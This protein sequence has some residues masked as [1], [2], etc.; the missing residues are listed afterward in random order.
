MKIN[1][2]ALFGLLCSVLAL[3]A[4]PAQAGGSQ[5]S[6]KWAFYKGTSG[7]QATVSGQ[8]ANVVTATVSNGSHLTFAG[9]KTLDNGL[10]ETRIGVTQSYEAT[11]TNDN[12]LTFRVAV[13][14]GYTFKVTRAAF[15]ATRVGTDQVSVDV[16]V[17]GKKL[18]TGLVPAR[19][20]ANPEFTTYSY[21]IADDKA[22][23][24]HNLSLNIYNLLN[25]KQV[26]IANVIVEGIVEETS[27]DDNQQQGGNQQ[28]DN[29]QS[30]QP[31]ISYPSQG[32]IYWTFKQ[33]TANQQP[34]LTSDFN[35]KVSGST[36]VGS[37]I[38]L[39]GQKVL[40]SGYTE[41]RVGVKVD[42][43]QGANDNNKLSFQVTPA[44]GYKVN[45]T[46]IQFTATQIGT[47]VGKLDVSWAGKKLATAVQPART[48]AD[49]EFTTYT[50]NVSTSN[51]EKAHKLTL[52]FYNMPTAKQFGIADIIFYG[53]IE[54]AE[55]Q[56]PSDQGGNSG[57]TYTPSKNL[58]EQVNGKTLAFPGAEGFGAFSVGG[59][60]GSV[61]HVTNLN[62][63]GA[64]SFADAIS[65][66][67]RII[68]FDVGGIINITGK[69]LICSDN[70]TIE[71]QTAPG[72]GI[73][74]YGG[75]LVAKGKNQIIRFIRVRGGIN[76]NKT[77]AAFTGDEATDLI[78]DHCS[79][80][81]G[82]WDNVH[83][84]DATRVTWQDCIISEGIDP[85]R[86]G[87]IVDG[88][89]Q[90]TISHCLW[91]DN[92]SRNPKMK[93]NAQMINSI[94]YN[95]QN[96]T[97]G[98]HS[99]A[100]WYQDV[101][102][103]YYISGPNTSSASYFSQWSATDHLYSAGN[104][105]DHNKNGRLDGQACTSY[106]GATRM[107]RP[108]NVSEV[109]VTVQSASDAYYTV[110]KGVGASL[111]R[112]S[113]DK[114]VISQV[115]SLGRSGQIINS[116]SNVGG[117]GTVRNGQKAKDSD[118]DGI[119]D[120]FEQKYGLN[121]H[122]NDAMAYTLSKRYTNIEVYCNSLVE[123]I[124]RESN[125]SSYSRSKGNDWEEEEETTTGVEEAVAD[126]A[127]EVES[128]RYYNLSGA[129]VSKS[130]A[131]GIVIVKTLYS[132]GKQTTRKMVI[133]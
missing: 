123:N 33:G 101:I 127:P 64:G 74:L 34:T 5:V 39:A 67:N 116:E 131:K 68:I 29:N 113:H 97:V 124:M 40:S 90:W 57:K 55:T 77:K 11:A 119:P 98:G 37:N 99:S 30:Q 27:V 28:Q 133:R 21:T 82:R 115:E 50:Y 6:V 9:T 16:S 110:V 1:Q 26:G 106:S 79:V 75:R 72:E 12:K 89:S 24:G 103:N 62:A 35:G 130:E 121:Q 104:F 92:H 23:S 58:T 95:Y 43:E 19:N 118:G 48:K 78:L 69:T 73:T 8:Y 66:P 38:T 94:V 3:F 114:R 88:T 51:P 61:Y 126:N 15:T 93:A 41:T 108:S 45:I 2:S 44:N 87:A 120:W 36:I 117:I 46:K 102:N 100:N 122:G 54:K 129:E 22:T 7:Q 13:A 17:S 14:D 125:P 4:T 20:K 49:P 86:F 42:N 53:T 91:A 85:Q 111:V 10:T 47:D 76:L 132:N 32:G 96:G 128:V 109:P 83:M 81:W 80:S 112:D 31:N 18:A 52:N 107:N 84:K 71:G 56:Q 63:S 65:R 70:I 105:Y 25:T 60:N 59:R